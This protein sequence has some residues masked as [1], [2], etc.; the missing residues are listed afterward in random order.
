MARNCV[1]DS[2]KGFAII[3]VVY[4]HCLQFLGIGNYWH[5]PIF[6][7]TY[8][9]HMPLFML[10]SGYFAISALKLD[11][12]NFLKEKFIHLLLPCFSA[13]IFVTLMNYILGLDVVHMGIREFVGNLWYLKSLFICMAIVKLFKSC[14]RNANVLFT[15]LIC[16]FI[17]LPIHFYHVNFMMPY[18][19]IGYLAFQYKS[20]IRR[21]VKMIYVL[22]ISIYAFLW[23]Y[24]DGLYTTYASPLKM[25][26]YISIQWIGFN[27]LYAYALRLFIGLSG[28]AMII[29]LFFIIEDY[30]GKIVS[31]S[32]LGKYTLEIYTI[33]FLFINTGLL[34]L[35]AVSY[36]KGWYEM[37]FCLL[38]AFFLLAV[39]VFIIKMIYRN[40][41]LS[42][43]FF[44]KKKY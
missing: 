44:G 18:F 32:K 39:C 13:A 3:C 25:F 27:N 26:D 34:S 22:S 23:Q 6:K 11:L 8:S 20:V 15:V 10:I 14:F 2:L 41:L 33:H 5:H 17:A 35:C 7:F 37:F 30:Q 16:L 19:C 36:I 24:W 9:F 40:R 29:A 38:I 43:L 12:Y 31:L 4:T 28:S 1:L 21:N 42:L